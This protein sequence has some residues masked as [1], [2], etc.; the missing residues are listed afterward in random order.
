V[1]AVEMLCA[2]QAIDL[3]APLTSTRALMGAHHAVR[4]VVPTLQD[5][6]APSV[7]IDAITRLLSS[8]A[9][10]YATGVPVN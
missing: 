3:R 7:D 2:C 4:A 1:L 5:D 10:E 6:R 9:L 8:G